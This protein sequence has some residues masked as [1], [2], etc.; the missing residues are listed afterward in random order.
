MKDYYQYKKLRGFLLPDAIYRMVRHT[1]RSY[2]YFMSVVNKIDNKS[3]ENKNDT[4]AENRIVAKQYIKA[5]EEALKEYVL[6]DYRD[7]VFDHTAYDEKIEYLCR[8]YYISEGTIKSYTQKFV[9]GV[10]EKLGLVL[11]RKK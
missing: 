7:A 11:P 8:K 6:E 4:D 2:P 3:E 10:A 9:F 1:I 5:I